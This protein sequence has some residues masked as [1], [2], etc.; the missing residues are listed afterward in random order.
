M[1]GYLVFF[2]IG[3]VV[4]IWAGLARLFLA[5]FPTNKPATSH[6]RPCSSVRFADGATAR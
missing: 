3:N 2:L 6:R 1:L 5:R 4:A